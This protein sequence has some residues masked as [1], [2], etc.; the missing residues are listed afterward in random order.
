MHLK[1]LKAQKLKNRK[2]VDEP[3]WKL[4]HLG[5]GLTQNDA[6]GY[7]RDACEARHSALVSE[8]LHLHCSNQAGSPLNEN[9]NLTLVSIPIVGFRSNCVVS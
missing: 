6:V 2:K 3:Y 1:S 5:V 9:G 8:S 4:T 7:L